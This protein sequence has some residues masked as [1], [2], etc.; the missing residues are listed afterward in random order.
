MTLM[1]SWEEFWSLLTCADKISALS[2]AEV[3]EDLVSVGLG[4]S[5]VDEEAGVAQLCD[6]LGQQ[7]HTLH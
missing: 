4:H 7:L 2:I 5:G 1:F 6:L 3:V